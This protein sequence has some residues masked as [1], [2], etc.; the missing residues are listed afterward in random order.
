MQR[1]NILLIAVLIGALALA[2]LSKVMP[3]KKEGVE[4][5]PEMLKLGMH[6]PVIW[7]FYNDSDVN[8]RN[9][10]D[11][12]AR[13]SNVINIPLLNLCYNSI[14]KAN[15]DKY[16]IQVVGGLQGVAERLGGW[17]AMPVFMRNP[18]GRVGV[19][20]EDWIRTALLAKYGGLWLSPSVVCLKGF[21]DLPTDKVVAFGQ[22]QESLYG[23]DVP[24]FRA[25][26]SPM[27]DHPIFV[28]WE[29]RIRDRLDNQLGGRQVRGD[30]KSEWAEFM[31]V[32][33]FG[34]LRTKEELGRDPRTNKTLDL[35]NL[36]ASG[37]GGRL[38]FAIPETAVYVPIPY[39]DL[40]NRRNFGWI[41]RNSEKQIMESDLAIRYILDGTYAKTT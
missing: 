35:E 31:A 21:G 28:E 11:F 6:L 36:L 10:S 17:E 16:L 4:I 9:W 27:P 32:G 18:K 19:A 26:W 25:L 30:C 15:G 41:L 22:D 33:A 13:S 29:Q 40:L 34:E 3:A 2:T 12:M 24:G 14:L 8:S 39:N 5:T 20:E 38:P 1:D 7:L 37:T 23:S